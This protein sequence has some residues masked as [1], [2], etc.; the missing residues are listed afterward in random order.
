MRHYLFIG[1]PWD[2]QRKLT[3]GQYDYWARQPRI[4]SQNPPHY[5]DGSR[6]IE[7]VVYR[8]KKWGADGSSFFFYAPMGM[9]D[10]LIMGA[11]IDFYSPGASR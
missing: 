1:G 5:P 2:G 8:L 11:L 10:A 7:T 3:D 9:S 4:P 6:R